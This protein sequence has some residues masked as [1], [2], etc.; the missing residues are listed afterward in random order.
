MDGD[1]EKFAE[2]LKEQIE[3]LRHAFKLP[4]IDTS[5]L[6]ATQRKTID[7]ITRATQMSSHAAAEISQRQRDILRATSE[8]V[9]SM[10]RDMKLS[11]DQ[12]RELAAKS[13]EKAL[14]SSRELAEMTAQSNAEVFD[15]VK[16]R[17]TE[18][19]EEMRKSWKP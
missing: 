16:R 1:T 7:A 15:F 6:I 11:A 17:M 9:A 8:H 10:V 3:Q 18:N 19:F 4:D 12:Q 14:A 13:F 2:N 5:A